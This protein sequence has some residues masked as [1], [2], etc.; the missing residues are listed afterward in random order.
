MPVTT[1]EPDAPRSTVDPLH[2]FKEGAFAKEGLSR[3]P[4]PLAST[5]IAVAVEG[6]FATVTTTRAF[7][8]AEADA[9]EAT[10]TWPVPLDAVAHGLRV[11]VDGRELVGV[12]SAKAE[13]RA[14]YEVALDAGRTAILHEE[15]LKGVHVLAVGN[16]A[17]GREVSVETRWSKPLALGG[18]LPSLRI[19]TTVA[20]I[21]GRMPLLPADDLLVDDVEVFEASLSVEAGAGVA[22]LRGGALAASG[23]TRVAMD[24]PIDLSFSGLA[25]GAAVGRAADGRRVE[26]TVSPGPA[27]DRD[28]RVAVLFDRSGSTR[29]PLAGAEGAAVK[30]WDCARDGLLAAVADLRPSDALDLFD[31]DDRIAHHGRARGPAEATR[32]VGRLGGPRGGTEI[33]KAVGAA[34]AVD[35]VDDVV[36]VT[37]GRSGAIPVLALA[38]R[39]KRVSAVICGENGLEALIGHLCVAT[40]GQVLV[41][42]GA[43]AAHCLRRVLEACRSAGSPATEGGLAAAP[44]DLTEVRG[45]SSV[46]VVV[47]GDRVA[48]AACDAVGAYA[49]ALSLPMLSAE[50]A[51]ATAV[52]HGLCTHLTSLL[53]VDEAGERVSGVP[54]QR[55]VPLSRPFEASP[56]AAFRSAAPR[57]HGLA[58]SAAGGMLRSSFSGS[59]RSSLAAS[60]SGSRSGGVLGGPPDA[61]ASLDGDD[62]FVARRPAPRASLP[63]LAAAIEWDAEAGALS[64]GGRPTLPAPERAAFEAALDSKAF[65]AFA[66]SVGRGSPD[67]AVALLVGL[68]AGSAPGRTAARIARRLLAGL[69]AAAIGRGLAA[70]GLRVPLHA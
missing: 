8:N 25:P 1:M 27:G 54:G 9:I 38:S 11:L 64:G 55:K 34:M 3:R 36:V 63:S 51:T 57:R 35:G 40:G 46:R 42:T 37:D 49:A 4:I 58:A 7:R 20:S 18:A 21:Y 67:A 33:G 15:A 69:D 50:A 32:L 31:F 26:L 12:A 70:L 13:A 45:G 56:A 68:L 60:W 28:L 14:S 29:D 22:H 66:A 24:L 65:A 59:G 62:P 5:A 39:G 2:A 23:P 10:L 16:V 17:P 19:P 48:G 53:V 30:V 47:S 61:F 6:P 52:A 43:D 44:D 41:S